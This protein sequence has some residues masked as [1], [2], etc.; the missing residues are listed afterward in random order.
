M[1]IKCELYAEIF[2]NENKFITDSAT[3]I[4]RE[5]N[6]SNFYCRKYKFEEWD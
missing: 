4:R 5:K 2:G 1:K 6:N 3:E